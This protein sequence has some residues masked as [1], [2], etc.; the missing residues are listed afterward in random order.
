MKN[1]IKKLLR[2]ALSTSKGN[3]LVKEPNSNIENS[4]TFNIL[5]KDG[6][7]IGQIELLDLT[8][9]DYFKEQGINGYIVT[10][11]KVNI[12]NEGLGRD[13][14]KTL[15]LKL[16]KPLFSDTSR[17]NDAN[18]MWDSLVIDGFAKYNPKLDRYY[19]IK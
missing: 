15:I 14:Y 18:K 2:E 12:R 7:N 9:I 11:S 5:N 6:N 17:S 10:N 8:N 3:L 13:A 1:L 4:F 16:D 19:S